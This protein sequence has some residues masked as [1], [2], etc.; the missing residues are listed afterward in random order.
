MLFDAIF[1]EYNTNLSKP[2]NYIPY[3]LVKISDTEFVL[4]F[5]VIGMSRDEIDV[6]VQNNKLYVSGEPKKSTERE[7]IINHISTKPF[8]LE[9]SLQEQIEVRS[10]KVKDGILTVNLELVIPDEKKPKKINIEH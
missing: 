10:A 4:E 6:E 7:Y 1:P 8:N 5:N 2:R 9:F 3:N